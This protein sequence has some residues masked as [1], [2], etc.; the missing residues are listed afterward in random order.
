M[1]NHSVVSDLTADRVVDFSETAIELCREI[2]IV[3]YKKKDL[4]LKLKAELMRINVIRAEDTYES[5]LR[6]NSFMGPF[7]TNL[8]T[9]LSDKPETSL[10]GLK[11]VSDHDLF[12]NMSTD[13][14]MRN[15]LKSKKIKGDM[16][17]LMLALASKR[18]NL[19]EWFRRLAKTVIFYM[20]LPLTPDSSVKKK[21]NSA[22][23][24]RITKDDVRKEAIMQLEKSKKRKVDDDENDDEEEDEPECFDKCT[25]KIKKSNSSK[26]EIS[27]AS[28][29][30]SNSS[31]ISINIDD[32]VPLPIDN[33]I[34]KGMK[35]IFNETVA[36]DDPEVKTYI[37]EV[38]NSYMKALLT[39]IQLLSISDEVEVKTWKLRPK[40]TEDEEDE[41]DEEGEY[42]EEGEE[43]GEYEEQEAPVIPVKKTKKPAE[44]MDD[45]EI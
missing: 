19:Y 9:Y 14:D 31:G 4:S 39:N 37:V 25:E 10:Y 43:E 40:P 33:N 44:A 36:S 20:Q 6:D 2:V 38:T 3:D 28:S 1:S 41:E 18:K 29:K 45:D 27:T 21:T 16:E 35:G 17:Q 12:H 23:K 11:I 15:F 32:I 24:P 7:R 22:K 5:L 8:A 26:S 30:R 42:E 34:M 13:R